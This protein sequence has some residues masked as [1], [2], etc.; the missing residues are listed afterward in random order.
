VWG[1]QLKL[2]ER[3]GVAIAMS[4]GLLAGMCAIIK[5]VYLIQLTQSDFFCKCGAR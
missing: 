4:M 3:V 5:G 2:R 1:L